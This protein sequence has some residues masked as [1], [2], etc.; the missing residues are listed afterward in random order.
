MTE[1]EKRPAELTLLAGELCLDFANTAEWHASDDPL[2]H[3]ESY[4]D[5]LAWAEHAEIIDSQTVIR[6][7]ASAA[8]HSEEARR[9]YERAIG[10]REA[11]YA[12]FAA[13]A[14]GDDPGQAD[15]ARINSDLARWLPRT[16]IADAGGRFIWQWAD[17]EDELEQPLWPI[18]RS[19]VSLLTSDQLDRVGQCADDRG[20][21]WLFLDESRNHS[22]RWCSMEDCG[23]RAKAKRFYERH[24]DAS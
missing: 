13:I 12:V 24:Q 1:T 17:E 7:R 14:Q 20:C 19:A 22:R 18:I 9:A 3:L 16:C 2:E 5:L 15:L 10:L 23:N 11:I 6:L 8:E 4:G 21:G